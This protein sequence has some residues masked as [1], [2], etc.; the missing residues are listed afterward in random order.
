MNFFL[1]IIVFISLFLFWKTTFFFGFLGINEKNSLWREPQ[2]N[3]PHNEGEPLHVK[4]HNHSYEAH[5]NTTIKFVN[6]YRIF[7]KLLFQQKFDT[8]Y[9]YC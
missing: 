1:K 9:T 3:K 6:S 7:K 2:H 8:K 5:H 4:N